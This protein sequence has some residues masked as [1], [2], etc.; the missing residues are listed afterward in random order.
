MK[1]C[2]LIRWPALCTGCGGSEGDGLMK[3]LSQAPLK[4]TFGGSL[5][6]PLSFI[7]SLLSLF[8]FRWSTHSTSE[9]STGFEHGFWGGGEFWVKTLK[10][11]SRWKHYTKVHR[12]N[13][14]PF[15]NCTLLFSV[16]F[17]EYLVWKSMLFEKYSSIK[18]T[19]LIWTR[20]C[21]LRIRTIKPAKPRAYWFF[22]FLC[23]RKWHF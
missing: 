12:A 1:E 19:W 8:L 22:F 7:T 15:F 20:T 14:I 21:A 11:Y 23:L 9:M 5:S 4:L 13:L 10:M 16:Y 3:T 6:A 17:K 18:R 2:T